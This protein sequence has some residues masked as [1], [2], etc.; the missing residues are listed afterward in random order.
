MVNIMFQRHMLYSVS[1]AMQYINVGLET[2]SLQ[3]VITG[4]PVLDLVHVHFIYSTTVSDF[5]T[6]L[7][8]KYLLT[9]APLPL[10]QGGSIHY[11]RI[12]EF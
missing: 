4:L 2:R 5:L 11:H 8:K 10:F 7:K 12:M 3:F 6:L 9:I 1:M